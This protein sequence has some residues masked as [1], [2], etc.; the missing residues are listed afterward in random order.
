MSNISLYPHIKETR[1]NEVVEFPQI[2]KYQ[3]GDHYKAQILKLRERVKNNADEKEIEQ[4]KSLLP[5]YT[6]SGVF[7]ERNKKGLIK[8][9]GKLAVDFDKLDKYTTIEEAKEKLI[10]DKYSEYIMLSCTGRGLCVIVNIDPSRH[11]DS[12][13]Y[14]EK[15]YK[16]NH[17]LIVDKSCKDQSRA[18]YITYDP[19]LYINLYPELVEVPVEVLTGT[20]DSDDEK[21]EWTKTIH[22]KKQQFVEGNRHHYIMVFAFFLNQ[23]GV[24][25]SYAKQRLLQEFIGNGKTP[26]EIVKI[27]DYCYKNVD[28]HGAFKINKKTSD[29][30]QGIAKQLSAVRATAHGINQAGREF[31]ENDIQSAA[32]QCDLSQTM[33]RDIFENVFKNHVD[34]HDIDNKPDIYKIERFILE[35]WDLRKNEITGRIEGKRRNSRENFGIVNVHEIQRD[36]MYS[37]FKF[38]LEKL[39]SLLRSEFV[40]IFHPFQGYFDS[41][42]EWDGVDYIDELAGFVE[43]DDQEFWKIQFKKAL[44]RSIACSLKNIEN[45]IIMTLVGKAQETGKS[46]YIR[47]LCPSELNDYYTETAMDGSKDSDIQMSE[48]F[49]WNLD[50]L[51]G[52]H[53]NEINKLKFIISKSKIKQRR[54]YG[55][56]YDSTPRR[57]NFWASTNTNDFLIDIQ[58]T[59]WLCFNVKNINHDYNNFKTGVK[60]IDIDNVWAQ[61]YELYQSG[62]N[63]HLTLAEASHRDKENEKF[64]Q[65]SFEK[66]L[67]LKYFEPCE[68]G[69][70]EFFTNSDILMR[71]CQITD[72]KHRFNS[73]AIGRALNQLGFSSAVRK[74]KGKTCRGFFMQWTS[75]IAKGNISKEKLQYEIDMGD[76]KPF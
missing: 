59:R 70:G 6:A 41:L 28:N 19:D 67:V 14:L 8:H 50:E 75:D 60:K 65:S 74:I 62:F 49:I 39:K 42:P 23:V 31:N 22:D 64:E 27:V 63:Y 54:A 69:Q 43:T 76:S 58:N 9:S 17:G 56:F 16:D 18:R 21:Y 71:L 36:L 40:P 47:F 33:V 5:Y 4:L 34:E 57:V 25:Y 15:Y 53:K 30:P 10:N 11:K 2:I 72:N 37:N 44:V 73:I 61:A 29:L 66:E 55:E 24:S 7:R 52:L 35:K 26:D 48:N 32:N 1:K 3:S 46:S 38:T 13:L 68:I 12:F 45:R 51:A 20:I